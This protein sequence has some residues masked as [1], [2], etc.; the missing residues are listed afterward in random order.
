ML[1]RRIGPVKQVRIAGYSVSHRFCSA[2]RRIAALRQ[3]AQTRTDFSAQRARPALDTP[4]GENNNRNTPYMQALKFA[5]PDA[6]LNDLVSYCKGFGR[7]AKKSQFDGDAQGARCT[8]HRRFMP[9][10]RISRRAALPVKTF[11]TYSSCIAVYRTR[12]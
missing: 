10:G 8:N 9:S 3:T 1:K 6:T 4:V 5:R 2:Q 12:S 11:Q 7:T